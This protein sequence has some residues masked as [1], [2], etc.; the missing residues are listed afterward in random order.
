MAT[1]TAVPSNIISTSSSPNKTASLSSSP[2]TTATTIATTDAT[3]PLPT[4]ERIMK[5]IPCPPNTR[6]TVYDVFDSRGK[7]RVDVLKTHFISEGRVTEDVALKII[8][9]G[10]KLLRLEKTMVDVEAPIT[11]CGDVHGQYFDL[12]KLFEVGGSPATTRYLFLGDYVDRGYFSIECVLY[13]WSMKILYPSTLFLLRGNHE[14]R[15]LTE[16]FTFKTECKIKYTERVYNACMEAFDCLPLAALMNGQFLCVHGG[17][18]PEIHTLEDIKKLDRFK[19]PPPYGPMCDL[20]WSDPLE[21]YGTERTTEQYSHNT[22]RGCSY[23]YSYA[24]CCDF[25]QN[26]QLLS[27]IRAHEAQDAGYRMYKKCQSTGFPSLITIFSAP[28]YLDVYNNKAAILKYEN[29]V[30]NIRQFNCSPHPYWLPNFMDVFTWSLPFVGEKVT[31]M[32]ANVLNICSD[33]ELQPDNTEPDDVDMTS[34]AALA[35]RKEVIRNK[36]R[37]VGKMVRYFATLREQS[38]DILTL[39]GLT[40]SGTLPLGTLEG[41]KI[42][43]DQAKQVIANKKKISFEEAKRLD[44]SNES[45]P[46]WQQL[47]SSSSGLTSGIGS[48]GTASSTSGSSSPRI[49]GTSAVPSMLVSSTASSSPPVNTLADASSGVTTNLLMDS[50]NTNCNG[51]D[52]ASGKP[53]NQQSSQ[54]RTK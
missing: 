11:V 35:A 28:N 25:L 21:D 34:E 49:V 27:I 15:H 54:H 47:H 5:T 24:A 46:P 29:N 41:G 7:P 30:M 12:M 10:A 52:K 18:S 38:E 1:S 51:N 43:I 50:T 16:Y 45:M 2:P 4:V 19:E 39:K 26:N 13:L 20:L 17:L 48:S 23:F 22:V 31:E 44:K 37:A 36:V 53:T 9:D 32:L 42:A 14:C 8:E 33:E 40:P 6:L 3:I